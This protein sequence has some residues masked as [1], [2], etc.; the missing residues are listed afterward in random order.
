MSKSIKVHVSGWLQRS[1][2][3]AMARP[4]TQ[5]LNTFIHL[6][7]LRG[8]GV[9]NYESEELSG[10]EAWSVAYVKHVPDAVVFDVGA[11][12]GRY[13]QF[14]T[15]EV[16]GVR[17]HAFEPHP[18]NFSRLSDGLRS[19]S[20]T[21]IQAAVGECRGE[22]SLYDYSDQEGSSHASLYKEAISDLRNSEVKALS[23]PVLTLDEYC[24]KNGVERISLLKIDT[25]GNELKCLLGAG[26]MLK[27]GRI[28]AVLFEFNEMNVFSGA[29]FKKFWDLLQGYK[30]YRLLPGGKLL[31]VK[32]Y[33][34]ATCEIYAY[35]N[36]VAL[37]RR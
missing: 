14:L 4:S 16:P 8:L 28:D 5:K 23:V 12:V 6:L 20:V 33:V 30:I 24:R 36:I 34:P 10:E 9:M 17:I 25:E 7:S 37:R 19:S 13:A 22:L 35:Q 32:Q 11:N 31:E 2:A 26:E 18:K 29:T 27:Q 21:C 1:W 15:K 3:R